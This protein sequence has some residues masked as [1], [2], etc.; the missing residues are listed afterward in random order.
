MNALRVEALRLIFPLGSTVLDVISV[1]EDFYHGEIVGVI[2]RRHVK[3]IRLTSGNNVSP[4]CLLINASLHKVTAI[5]LLIILSC[6]LFLI[7]REE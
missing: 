4:A 7:S 5:P 3:R 1:F 2:S 6:F